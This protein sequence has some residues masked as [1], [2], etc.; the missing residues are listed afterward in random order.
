MNF[1]LEKL[2]LILICILFIL[3]IYAFYRS[4]IY[5]NGNKRDYYINYQIFFILTI[6]S[7]YFFKYLNINI[8]KYLFISI[9][10]IILSL[11]L[12]EGYLILKILEKNKLQSK[13]EGS[14]QIKQKIYEDKTGKEFDTRD[15]L[16]IFNDL[17][18]EYPNI[19]VPTIPSSYLNQKNT[20]FPLS[21]ISNVRKVVCNEN[22]YYSFTISDRYGFN[23]PNYEWDKK[24][25]EYILIGDS[26]TYGSCVNKPNDIASQLRALSNKSVLNLGY[27]GNGPL[28]EYAVL[29]EYMR[30]NVNK[31]IWLYYE[32]ND[33]SN[34]IAELNDEILKNYLNDSK[35]SQNLKN[36]QNEI[37]T[38]ATKKLENAKFNIDENDHEE[39]LLFKFSQFLKFFNIRYLL[40]NRYPISEFEKILI[41][42]KNLTEKNG[43]KFYFVYLPE[44]ARYAQP[45]FDNK[46]YLE[47]KKI[48]NK[49]E[50]PFIDVHTEV[51]LK[52]DNPLDLFPFKLYG[53]FTPE[54][55]KKVSEIIFKRSL[56]N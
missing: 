23:N 22:G 5:W 1:F 46:Y 43:A 17:K 32:E 41:L 44:Y 4:E 47:I 51:F 52:E 56:S 7:I 21:G 6:F 42:A 34:L 54:A 31:V 37:N 39:R 33:L 18:K 19:K 50:I 3:L 45:N 48:I 2:R 53:H 13:F 24:N 36:R 16:T 27:G 14:Q 29:R 38:I 55:Y 15:R 20:I 25:T 11:Y 10:S 12:F 9:L 26:F 49:L 35:F 40:K 8:Q 30:P 28:I